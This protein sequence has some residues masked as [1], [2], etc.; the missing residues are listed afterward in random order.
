MLARLNSVV[1]RATEITT[2]G[3]SV[4]NGL[5]SFGSFWAGSRVVVNHQHIKSTLFVFFAVVLAASPLEDINIARK[6][7]QILSK[8]QENLRASDPPSSTASGR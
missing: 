5:N 8:L 2:L 7:S 6:I 4:T 1:A 3:G